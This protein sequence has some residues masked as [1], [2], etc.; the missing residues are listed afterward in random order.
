MLSSAMLFRSMGPSLL[1]AADCGNHKAT[2][3]IWNR[4]FILLL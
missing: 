2:P 3:L 4:N 1:D